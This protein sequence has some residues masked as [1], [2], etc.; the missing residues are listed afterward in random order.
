MPNTGAGYQQWREAVAVCE[1]DTLPA[2]SLA[3]TYRGGA[4]MTH[5]EA[6]EER[7]N[8]AAGFERGVQ[9][10]HEE[11]LRA[12]RDKDAE[13]RI[14]HILRNAKYNGK[15]REKQAAYDKEGSTTWLYSEGQW[16]RQVSWGDSAIARSVA[17]AV[18][19]EPEGFQ[20]AAR[21]WLVARLWVLQ[22]V[23]RVSHVWVPER[24]VS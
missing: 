18:A 13:D 6:V 14:G 5:A 8:I 4:M 9:Q 10:V 24:E 7:R 22:Y 16:L 21:A 11:A 12:N 20:W 3:G 23:Q 19:E 17:D 15:G 2:W 1:E